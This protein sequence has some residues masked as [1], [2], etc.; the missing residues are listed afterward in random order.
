M[1]E[2]YQPTIALQSLGSVELEAL[3][4]CSYTGSLLLSWGSVFETTVT[5]LQLQVK[6]ALALCLDFLHQRIDPSSCLD[7]ASFAEAYG[8]A[9]LQELAEDYVL[10]HFNEVAATPKFLDLPSDKLLKYLRSDSLYV[11]SE[12]VVFRAVV[13]WIEADPTERM[14][15]AQDLMKEVQFPLMTF[16]EF[17]EVKAVDLWRACSDTLDLC[18]SSFSSLEEQCR[19]YY[20]K[21]KLVLVGGDQITADFNKRL[22]SRKLWY[23][24]TIRSRTG[25]VREIEWRMLGEMPESPRF[26]HA[27]GVLEGNLYIIGGRHYYGTVDTMN[28]AYRYNPLENTWQRLA[29]M[30]EQRSNFSLVVRDQRIYAIGG[31]RDINNNLDSVECYCPESNCWRSLDQSL[32]GHAAAVWDGEIFISGGFD[33]RYQCLVSMFLYHPERGT[34]YLCDMS[35][36]RALHCMEKL[37]GHLYVA[38]GVCNLRK[39]YTDQLLCERYDPLTDSWS[40]IPSLRIPH[41]SGASAVLEDKIY[42]LGGYCQ[43]D[44]SESGLVHRYDPATLRWENMGRMPGPNTYIRACILHFPSQL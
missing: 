2:S 5:A 22:P 10:R 16:R 18:W 34:T 37:A 12:L 3:L 19:V 17:H 44:Y 27:V 4:N 38:G 11:P 21:D 25:L 33:C 15:F 9:D 29:D 24:N 26:S 20:P 36:D 8:L 7:V 31:D 42:I 30:H 41:V 13:A 40:S 14:G 43:E 32:S 35:Q 28:S 1:R 6:S 39:F 23:A